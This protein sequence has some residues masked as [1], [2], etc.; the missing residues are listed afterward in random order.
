MMFSVKLYLNQRVDFFFIQ[1]KLAQKLKGNKWKTSSTSAT[2]SCNWLRDVDD[3]I[4]HNNMHTDQQDILNAVAQNKNTKQ[5][6]R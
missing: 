5:N 4:T 2:Y 6:D 3:L 1:I